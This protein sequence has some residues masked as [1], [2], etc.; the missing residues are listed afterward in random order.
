[1]LRVSTSAGARSQ[2]SS[3][4]LRIPLPVEVRRAHALDPFRSVR[5]VREGLQARGCTSNEHDRAVRELL[6]EPLQG[7]VSEPYVDEDPGAHG[8][9]RHLPTVSASNSGNLKAHQVD[10][11][12]YNGRSRTPLQKAV[13]GFTILVTWVSG[14]SPTGS[15]IDRS[16]A[17]PM[18]LSIEEST[19]KRARSRLSSVRIGATNT[20]GADSN[21]RSKSNHNSAIRT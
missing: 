13:T 5:C 16:V 8:D 10:S 12:R 21:A 4:R 17:A 19:V 11:D 14:G 20:H 1:M 6:P 9:D 3:G 15:T 18:Q 2:G 7:F